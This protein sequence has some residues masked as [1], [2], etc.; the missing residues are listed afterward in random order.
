MNENAKFEEYFDEILRWYRSDGNKRLRPELEAALTRWKSAREF[1]L[2]RRP[3]VDS[4]TVQFIVMTA[5]VSEATAWRDVRNAKRLFAS[6]EA[7]N[8]EF[9]QIMLLADMKDLRV[10]ALLKNKHDVAAK[11]DATRQKVLERVSAQTETEQGTKQIV[12]NL[13]FNPALVGA[14]P[15][16]KLLE[17]VEKFI[18][19]KA[20]REL[21][22][23]DDLTDIAHESAD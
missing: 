3:L 4:E 23:D 13:T 21:M 5:G 7:V 22:I 18:G 6:M 14:K 12:L 2:T 1:I 10:Q 17:Q 11:C 16:P 15:N 20:R 19:E 8:I 9:E